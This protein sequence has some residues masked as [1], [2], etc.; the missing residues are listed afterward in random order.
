MMKHV[1]LLIILITIATVAHGKVFKIFKEKPEYCDSLKKDANPKGIK[2]SMSISF[3]GRA[4]KRGILA[5]DSEYI[6]SVIEGVET[7]SEGTCGLPTLKKLFKNTGGDE[8]AKEDEE[9]PKATDP[10][11]C[12]KHGDDGTAC[13]ANPNCNFNVLAKDGEGCFLVDE[14]NSPSSE[15]F[16][17]V[18]NSIFKSNDVD[19]FAD[20]LAELEKIGSKSGACPLEEKIIEKAGAEIIKASS[21]SSSTSSSQK[22]KVK[23]VLKK[24]PTAKKKDGRKP[25]CGKYDDFPKK[26]VKIEGCKYNLL[27]GGC[28]AEGWFRL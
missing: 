21:S 20:A 5:K 2:R 4:I 27:K 17:N 12:A 13:I 9:A 19:S 22:K 7:C 26:C 16:D 10:E 18:R 14:S 15:W 8:A 24:Q 6:A 3:A 1:S 11:E 25:N 28:K 23:K